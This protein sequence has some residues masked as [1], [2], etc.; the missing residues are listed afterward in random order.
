MA[1]VT[2]ADTG[3]GLPENADNLFQPF[4]TSKATGMGVG[5]AICQRIVQAHGGAI[6]AGNRADGQGAVFRFTTPFAAGAAN[7]AGAG[8]SVGAAVSGS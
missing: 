8:A 4:V 5:L 2:V 1:E 7:D 6:A 3:P